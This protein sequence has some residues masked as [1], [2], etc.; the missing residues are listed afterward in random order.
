MG[1]K[2]SISINISG[3]KKRIL[4]PDLKKYANSRLKHYCNDYV[5]FL[6]G[7]LAGTARASEDGVFYTMP[8][9]AYQYTGS[10]FNFTK[11]YHPLATAY[12][13]KA[14]MATKGDSLLK[15]VEN[16]IKKGI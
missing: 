8:Y 11:D 13:D 3:I 2:V 10:N 1:I 5:P 12:W 4:T 6:S 7:D 15:D 14:M 16:A 9:A